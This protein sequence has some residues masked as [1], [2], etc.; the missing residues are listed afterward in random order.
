MNQSQFDRLVERTCS[1]TVTD[2][3]TPLALL[4]VDSLRTVALLMAVEDEFEVELDP[5]VLADPAQ[6]T[7]EG[8]W[9][10]VQERVAAGTG[11]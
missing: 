1:V 7:P 11:R 4:G 8:L 5:R 9:R 6:A 3:D 2:R 10:A